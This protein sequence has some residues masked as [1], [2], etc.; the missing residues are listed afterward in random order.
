MKCINQ[1][2][3][4][5]NCMSGTELGI[6]KYER[7]SVSGHVMCNNFISENYRLTHP[8][9]WPNCRNTM[10]KDTKYFNWYNPTENWHHSPLAQISL[11]TSWH[12]SWQWEAR[13]QSLATN[14]SLVFLSWWPRN[15]DKINIGLPGARIDHNYAPLFLLR[16]LI[17]IQHPKIFHPKHI[18]FE[19][20]DKRW[21]FALFIWIIICLL[22][23]LPSYIR[24]W[25]LS[26]WFESV[27][28]DFLL[29]TQLRCWS[30]DPG[31]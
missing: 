29:W 8:E 4:D 27:I 18:S 5:Y 28:Y 7:A 19:P 25:K 21:E 12:G 16:L 10:V 9:P 20:N 15:Y 22:N 23:I 11:M 30:P 14:L 26:W 13:R 2:Q 6:I 17:I 1:G 24:S 31:V 3:W